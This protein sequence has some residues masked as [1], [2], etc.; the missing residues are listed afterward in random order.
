MSKRVEIRGLDT[1]TLSKLKSK[2]MK[3]LLVKLKAGDNN[4]RLEFINA[5]IALLSKTST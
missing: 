1:S 5:S 3:E 4:A 2:E